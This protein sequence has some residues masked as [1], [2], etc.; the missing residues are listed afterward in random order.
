MLKRKAPVNRFNQNNKK[1]KKNFT[2]KKPKQVNYI[3]L[4]DEFNKTTTENGAIRYFIFYI[5]VK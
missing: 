3:S 2:K 4:I 5:N 1:A